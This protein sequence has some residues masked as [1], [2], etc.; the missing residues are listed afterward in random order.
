MLSGFL[1]EGGA[2]GG[3]FDGG[4]PGGGGFPSRP[5]GP[6]TGPVPGPGPGAAAN[7]AIKRET[8]IIKANLLKRLII[9]SFIGLILGGNN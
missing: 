6:V 1:G 9:K 5:L 8:V 2:G 7:A 3:F 4:G